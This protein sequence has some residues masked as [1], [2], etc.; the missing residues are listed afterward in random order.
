MSTVTPK[1]LLFT[2][3]VGEPKKIAIG[4]DESDGM[5]IILPFVM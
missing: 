5:W 4:K 1:V 3:D 2:M